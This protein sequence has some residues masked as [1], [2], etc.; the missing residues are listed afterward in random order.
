MNIRDAI[1][2]A[3]ETGAEI[4]SVVGKIKSVDTTERTCVVEPVDGSPEINGVRYTVTNG[5]SSGF[6]LNPKSG[7]FV[8]VTF[9]DDNNGF[10]SLIT[11]FDT[12]VL[13]NGTADLK[14]ILTDLIAQIKV[15]T[16][17]TPSGASSTP[18]NA[19]AFDPIQ[20][21]IDNLFEQ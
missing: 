12:V 20:Q 3:V 1:R 11:E 5:D 15:I 2:K 8:I 19:T 4:Y 7:S 10:I 9:L 21:S 18:I 6:I 16:V 13:N 14:Q 17:P